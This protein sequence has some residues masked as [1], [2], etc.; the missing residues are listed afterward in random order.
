MEQNHITCAKAVAKSTDMMKIARE[1]PSTGGE[2]NRCCRGRL[3]SAARG[4]MED[5]LKCVSQAIAKYPNQHKQTSE[6]TSDMLMSSKHRKLR[7]KHSDQQIECYRLLVE[8]RR[9]YMVKNEKTKQSQVLTATAIKAISHKLPRT[10]EDLLC[11]CNKKHLP[12]AARSSVNE[13]LK[14][15]N[16][17]IARYP[18][19]T[20]L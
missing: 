10:V 17:A 13:L 18:E 12:G 3:P 7:K 6:G 2:L 15:V 8:W 20:P 1:L 11:C 14:C 16:E 5:L 19:P 9:N 4:Q